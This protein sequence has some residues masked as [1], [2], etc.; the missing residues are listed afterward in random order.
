MQEQEKIWRKSIKERNKTVSSR[1]K[2][3]T[4]LLCLNL[5]HLE[6]ESMARVIY[7]CL[8]CAKVSSTRHG[9]E[10]SQKQSWY[11]SSWM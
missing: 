9:E 11:S 5:S 7:V 2:T 6:I 1:T 10:M 8:V 3:E 4:P